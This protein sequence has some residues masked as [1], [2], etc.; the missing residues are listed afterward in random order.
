MKEKLQTKVQEVSL[1]LAEMGDLP[2]KAARKAKRKS[3]IQ[4]ESL[5][6]QDWKHRLSMRE[7]AGAERDMH[8][9]AT[10]GWVID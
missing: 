5:A 7:A 3:R 10:R 4:T 9:G 6:E 1:L 8:D 2:E